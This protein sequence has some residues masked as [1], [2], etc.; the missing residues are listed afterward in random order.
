MKGGLNFKKQ[1]VPS[2]EEG[3]NEQI[4]FEEVELMQLDILADI[5]VSIILNEN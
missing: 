4:A 1:S 2:T 3:K 5:L